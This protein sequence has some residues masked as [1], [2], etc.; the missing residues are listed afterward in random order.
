M[1]CSLKRE[2]QSL[3]QLATSAVAKD[4]IVTDA[5]E[6]QVDGVEAAVGLAVRATRHGLL[7]LGERT[8]F[9]IGE[10]TGTA[11]AVILTTSNGRTSLL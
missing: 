8:G 2:I 6:Q 11:D 7:K 9:L 1:P 4:M 10:L 5:D 3:R